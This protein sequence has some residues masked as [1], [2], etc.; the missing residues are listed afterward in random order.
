[1]GIS[2]QTRGQA[3]GQK[4][5]WSYRRYNRHRHQRVTSRVAGRF[6]VLFALHCT[7]TCALLHML[8]SRAAKPRAGQGKGVKDGEGVDRIG[9]L[10]IIHPPPS[11][12]LAFFQ[13][14]LEA[15]SCT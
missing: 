8:N 1:M 2:V 5:N 15:P 14:R 6:G 11:L 7:V 12:Q 9:E 13:P 10:N 3:G 4:K